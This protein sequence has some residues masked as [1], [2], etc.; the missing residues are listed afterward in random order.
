[1]QYSVP[2][3]DTITPLSF[4][5]NTVVVDIIFKDPLFRLRYKDEDYGIYDRTFIPLGKSD[6]L[7][8]STPLILLPLYL[9]GS[10]P[11]LS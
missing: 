10:S 4:V 2:Y 1:L 11:S 7:G 3:I 5:N 9:S 6:Q 8:L